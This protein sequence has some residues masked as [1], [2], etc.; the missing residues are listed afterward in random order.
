MASSVHPTTI[1]QPSVD[2]ESVSPLSKPN[3]AAAP[4]TM[5]SFANYRTNPTSRDIVLPSVSADAPCPVYAAQREAHHAGL[6]QVGSRASTALR[7]GR[8]VACFNLYP[9]CRR[10]LD[11][12][13]LLWTAATNGEYDPATGNVLLENNV[14]ALAYPLAFYNILA[15]V[16]RHE[17]SLCMR[18][19]LAKIADGEDNEGLNLMKQELEPSVWEDL[20]SHMR[21]KDME[22]SL[23]APSD[24]DNA[25]HPA[26]AASDNHR[27][28]GEQEQEQI[29]NA[30]SAKRV[31]EKELMRHVDLLLLLCNHSPWKIEVYASFVTPRDMGL[32]LTDLTSSARANAHEAEGVAMGDTADRPLVR[33][34]ARRPVWVL[35]ERGAANGGH[36]GSG[37]GSGVSGGS[38]AGKLSMESRLSNKKLAFWRQFQNWRMYRRVLVEGCGIDPVVVTEAMLGTIANGT[39]EDARLRAEV[40]MACACVEGNLLSAL[41]KEVVFRYIAPYVLLAG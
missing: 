4:A 3:T 30:I 16:T 11:I 32:I 41:P 1:S 13:H 7:Y 22:Q 12:N 24:P 36:G 38:G 27:E 17:L 19:V 28:Q 21:S 9:G 31:R 5:L 34:A 15:S 6:F 23:S 10:D 14:L 26:L 40:V 25:T 35:R 2:A 8:S 39:I 20:M 18:E 33:S 37:G 29:E